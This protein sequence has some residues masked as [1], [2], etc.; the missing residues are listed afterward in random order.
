M[1]MQCTGKSGWGSEALAFSVS[2]SSVFSASSVFL[3]LP[4][5]LGN[6]S[7][8]MR[9]CGQLVSPSWAL[10]TERPPQPVSSL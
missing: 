1:Q 8:R 7:S 5:V 10:L 2:S 6:V 9:V 3:R 4:V